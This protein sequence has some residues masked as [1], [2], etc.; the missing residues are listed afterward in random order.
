MKI[1]IGNLREIETAYNVIEKFEKVSGLEMHR[2]PAR[3]NAKHYHLESI[4]NL[5]V[6][7]LG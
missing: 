1:F 6:G 7:L 3:Q 5:M 4:E 2:D